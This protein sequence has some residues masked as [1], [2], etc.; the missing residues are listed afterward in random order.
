MP[1]ALFLGS[2]LSTQD[3]VSHFSPEFLPSNPPQQKSLKDKVKQFFRTARQRDP[4]QDHPVSYLSRENN[5]LVFIQKH[6]NH[7]I[8]DVVLSLLTLAVPINSAQVLCSILGFLLIT[9]T[10]VF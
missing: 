7:A 9:P 3:R 8:V 10:L 4:S 2:F 6:L 1:H 5:S